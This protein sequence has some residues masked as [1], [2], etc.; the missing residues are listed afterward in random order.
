MLHTKAWEVATDWT[1][2]IAQLAGNQG[3]GIQAGKE[4]VG[5][6]TDSDTERMLYLNAISQSKHK[7]YIKVIQGTLKLL[8]AKW[9]LH[10]TE[11]CIHKS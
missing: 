7:T 8:T 1:Q 2:W 3:P 6:Q 9:F 4:S 10:K 5:W 11:E